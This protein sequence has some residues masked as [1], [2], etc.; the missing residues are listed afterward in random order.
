MYALI[1][2]TVS[3]SVDLDP[4]LPMIINGLQQLKKEPGPDG[5]VTGNLDDGLEEREGVSVAIPTVTFSKMD[6]KVQARAD[7]LS[8]RIQVEIDTIQGLSSSSFDCKGGKVHCGA[9][10]GMTFL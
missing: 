5:E 8:Q 3:G 10:V 2:E 6:P 9:S 4:A 7:R 1:Y